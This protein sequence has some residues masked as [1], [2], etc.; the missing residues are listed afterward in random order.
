MFYQ[1]FILFFIFNV[2]TLFLLFLLFLPLIITLIYSMWIKIHII[3]LEC[4]LSVFPSGCRW[5][6]TV[7]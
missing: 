3:R 1:T 2:F 5:P 4:E 7:L 6:A